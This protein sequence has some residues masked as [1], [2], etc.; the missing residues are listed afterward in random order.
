[1]SS[2]YA[3]GRARIEAN[4]TPMIDMTFLLIVF[5]V[6]VSRI[7][8]VESVPM[9]LPE[10]Q[11]AA[12]V[13][14]PDESRVVLNVLPGPDGG[15]EGYRVG[16]MQF[17]PTPEGAEALERHLATLFRQNPELDVNLRADRATAYSDVAPALGAIASAARL[18]ESPEATRV[19]LVVIKDERRG[20]RP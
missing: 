1:M 5:F 18:A 3:R 6:L 9:E 10:P 20:P 12:T 16:V 17:A 14:L 4:L 15:I 2:V 19:N 8:E 7:S 13:P 11:E